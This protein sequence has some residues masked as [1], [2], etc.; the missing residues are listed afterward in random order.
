MSAPPRPPA[1]HRERWLLGALLC[2]VTLL[3]VPTPAYGERNLRV[4]LYDNSPKV[5][6]DA[7]GK[8]EG[9]FVDIIEAIAAAEGWR[10]TYVFGTWQQGLDRLERGA[11][12]LMP[13]VAFNAERD[14]RFA[15]HQEPVL[16]SWSQVYAPR[17]TTIRSLPDL[18][19][20][21]VAV[22]EGSVQQDEFTSMV[23]GFG[24]RV[25]LVEVPDF[26][27]AFRAVAEG[28]ADAVVTNRFYGVRHAAAMGLVD[29]AIIFS[30]S[31]LFFAAPRTGDPAILAAI[32][33][34]LKQLKADSSSVYYDSLRRWA[35]QQAPTAWPSWLRWVG[36]AAVLLLLVA[37]LWS[38][39]LRRTAKRLRASD[40]RQ[41]RLLGEL[42]IAKDAAEAADRTKSAFLATMSHELRTPLNSIIGFSGIMLQGLP[43]PLNPEQRKQLGM[44]HQSAKHLLE[45]IND[46][47]DL[48]KIEAG[49]LQIELRPFDLRASIEKS[50]A[51]LQPQAKGKGLALDMKLSDEVGAITS[52]QRRVEQVLLNLLS[53]AIKFTET[54]R[55]TVEATREDGAIVISVIDTGMGIREQDLPL[56]FKPFSQVDAG[57]NKRFEGTGLGLS[58]CK[59]LVGR[60]GGDIRV[61]SRWGEGSRFSFELPTEPPP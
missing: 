1:G 54:G 34:R 20:R 9:I 7:H 21:R 57:S 31:R 6:R 37:F 27:A 17:G 16:S 13:D 28:R 61:E 33:R 25:I 44:V 59:R 45:L 38:V 8:P 5:G 46:V 55:V 11:L 23:D 51:A 30:P 22:L 58:I 4:G 36:V 12:D 42:A 48:S 47:L 24:L 29:T 10:L 50:V 14:R 56:L 39:T 35:V 52:D 2:A 41:R 60:L 40:K 19:G 15:F 26:A 32:D 43:G 18:D 3:L 53:N 49:Q